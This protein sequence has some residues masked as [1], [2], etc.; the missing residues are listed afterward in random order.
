MIIHC[1]PNKVKMFQ[2]NSG[3]WSLL[4]VTLSHTLTPHSINMFQLHFAMTRND[5]VFS[6]HR[7]FLCTSLPTQE[8][9]LNFHLIYASP[10][11]YLRDYFLTWQDKVSRVCVCLT[12]QWALFPLQ[13]LI[14][15]FSHFLIYFYFPLSLSSQIEKWNYVIFKMILTF[16]H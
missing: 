3:P 6:L 4:V 14:I 1:P 9:Y 12:L 11:C 15:L 5:H 7:T 2:H 16:W 8:T 13:H 10:L